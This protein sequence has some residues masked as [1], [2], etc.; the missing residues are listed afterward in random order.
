MIDAGKL[1]LLQKMYKEWPFFSV[2]MDMIEMVFAKAD[3]RVAQARPQP[4]PPLQWSFLCCWLGRMAPVDCLH[5]LT[6]MVA[7]ACW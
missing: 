3:P 2:T 4:V 5:G 1:E 7:C 6:C